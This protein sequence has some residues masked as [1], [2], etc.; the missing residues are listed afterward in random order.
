M[1][2]LAKLLGAQEEKQASTD[3]LGLEP[4]NTSKEKK[5][6]GLDKKLIKFAG[7]AANYLMGAESE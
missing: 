6:K 2:N 7:K 1:K 5:K 3:L 4:D